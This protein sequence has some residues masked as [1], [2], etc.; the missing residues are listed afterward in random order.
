MTTDQFHL[1]LDNFEASRVGNSVRVTFRD[2]YRMIAAMLAGNLEAAQSE[3]AR[4]TQVRTLA[5]ELLAALPEVSAY[6]LASELM[7]SIHRR[8]LDELEHST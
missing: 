1:H 8:E 5:A 3:D 2:D 4:Y 6:H 7:D